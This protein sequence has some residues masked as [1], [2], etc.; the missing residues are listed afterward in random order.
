MEIITMSQDQVKWNGPWKKPTSAC[1]QLSLCIRLCMHVL[2]SVRVCASNSVWHLPT[3]VR[4][5]SEFLSESPPDAV[6]GNVV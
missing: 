3:T 4:F 2:Y 5:V 1:V 6:R